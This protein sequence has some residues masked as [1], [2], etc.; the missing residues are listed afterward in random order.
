MKT[1]ACTAAAAILL[2]AAAG[3]ALWSVARE[4]KLTAR[5]ADAREAA[6][7]EELAALQNAREALEAR[8]AELEAA[9]ATA[10]ESP[11]V[12]PLAEASSGGVA[13]A[14]K[15]GAAAEPVPA[16]AGDAPATPEEKLDRGLEVLLDPAKSWDEK[17]RAWKDLA[18]AGLIDRAVEAFERRARESPGSADAQAEA[19]MAY[20]QKL[21]TLANDIEKGT[22]AAKADR[23]FDAALAIDDRHWDARFMKAMSLSFWPPVFGK[24]GEAIR[25]FE[26][27]REQ[28]AEAPLQ[29]RFAE[30][31]LLLGNLYRNRGEAEKAAEVWRDGARRFPGNKDLTARAGEEETK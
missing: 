23:S 19:G 5:A 24:Q 3:G 20:I 10:A 6:L 21:N 16:A 15:D 8:V 7:R 30:T 1:I 14:A 31:Y 11:A 12:R 9:R 17:Q 13:L 27:L 18:D 26:V 29:E 28:Q 2:S 22:W 4:R 25:Q